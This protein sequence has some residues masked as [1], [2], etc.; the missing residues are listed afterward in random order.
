MKKRIIF[1]LSL[2]VYSSFTFFTCGVSCAG[3]PVAVAQLVLPIPASH[4]LSI[5]RTGPGNVTA[6]PAG[7][8][9]SSKYSIVPGSTCLTYN[10][11]GVTITLTATPTPGNLF[12][13][14]GGACKGTSAKCLLTLTQ[15]T[16][17][18]A[19]FA[20]PQYS[21]SVTKSS[22]GSE[23]VSSSP[24]GINCG[25]VCS[26]KYN[27]GTNVTL[28]AAPVHC[29]SE[30]SNWGPGCSGFPGCTLAI[31][32]DT[33]VSAYFRPLDATYPADRNASRPM[34]AECYYC[35][36]PVGQTTL[37]CKLGAMPVPMW[38]YD[39]R[40]CDPT[41]EWCIAHRNDPTVSRIYDLLC[42]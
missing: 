29:I 21:L 24:A 22:Q 13:G 26:A 37:I 14:W 42:K 38:E 28:T 6:T 35:T 3:D 9:C 32:Q 19:K 8:S 20:V 15:D 25:S 10:K 18:T 2:L 11:P 7:V 16:S 40:D 12:L 1:A 31:N 27:K 36:A 23:T 30:F 39:P 17:V 33:Q 34:C 41:R 5:T 4:N